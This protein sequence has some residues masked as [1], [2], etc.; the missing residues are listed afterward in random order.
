M[1]KKQTIRLNESQLRRIVKESVKRVLKEEYGVD[2]ED[3]LRWVQKKNPN[4]SPEEQERFAKNIIRKREHDKYRFRISMDI[5]NHDYRNLKDL[6]WNEAKQCYKKYGRYIDMIE[7]QD[8][9]H[10]PYEWREFNPSAFFDED[11]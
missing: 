10:D 6:S 4:M 5:P 7:Y 11:E 1:N 8:K 3:T 9:T 2:F